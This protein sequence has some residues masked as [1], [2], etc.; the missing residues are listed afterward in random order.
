MF[1]HRDLPSQPGTMRRLL[2]RTVLTRGGHKRVEGYPSTSERSRTP[3]KPPPG[4]CMCENGDGRT[5][6]RLVRVEIAGYGDALIRHQGVDD[7]GVV[8]LAALEVEAVGPA[9]A[10]LVEIGP[11][12]GLSQWTSN[13]S[14][15]SPMR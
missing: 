11:M 9:D 14:F 8:V 4:F 7:L 1:R 5:A 15:E 12:Y 3:A 6:N 2:S 13:W 10:L